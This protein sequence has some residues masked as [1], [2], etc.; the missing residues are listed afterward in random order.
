MIAM[1][2]NIDARFQ[3]LD[4]LVRRN[5]RR[6]DFLGTKLPGNDL[7]LRS[8]THLVDE[9]LEF[10]VAWICLASTPARRVLQLFDAEWL[11]DLEHLVSG[12]RWN[13]QMRLMTLIVE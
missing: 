7:T 4:D 13:L 5:S 9:Y 8:C 12:Q 2:R 1:R 6:C 3:L 11:A 10:F